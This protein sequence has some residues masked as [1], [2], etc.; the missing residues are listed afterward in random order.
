MTGLYVVLA[1][2]GFSSWL[3]LAHPRKTLL[4]AVFFIPW[5]GLDVD[6]GLRVTAYLVFITPLFAATVFRSLVKTRQ[7]LHLGAFWLIV[8]YAVIWSA[9]QLPFLPVENVVGG[10]LRQ[11][12]VR[13][14]FQILMFLITISPIW[15][16]P[17]YIRDRAGLLQMGKCYLVSVGILALIGWMQLAIWIATGTDPF[18]VG[19]FNGLLGGM[20]GERSGMFQ[21]TG[22]VIYRMSSF[23][24][25]PKGLGIGLAVALLLLQ[26]G[27]SLKGSWGRW[28]WPFLFIS[29]V[30]TF[31]TMALLGWLGATVVQLF[32]SSEGRLKAPDFLSSRHGVKRMFLWS[33]PVLMLAVVAAQSIPVFELIHMRTTTRIVE[34]DR[35]ALEEFNVAVLDFLLAHPWWA[36]VGTGLGNVHLYADSFLPEYAVRYAEG[37]PFV[38]KS[39]ALRWVSELGLL[40]L[41]GF[42]GWIFSTSSKN[43]RLA[44]NFP[45]WQY[46]LG[47]VVK[48]LLPLM[49]LWFVS[50][51]IAPQFYITIGVC[52]ATGTIIRRECLSSNFDSNSGVESCK[53]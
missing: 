43:A 41:I 22:G 6:I 39:G 30:A 18:P 53:Q 40:T 16:V 51:Y 44:R 10:A 25:E 27:V 21:Y 19:F 9:C 35:L 17:T 52:V 23:G 48:L 32:V 20:G 4:V 31:S 8:I 7:R 47:I 45:G 14:T 46:L 28:F 3:A 11:P 33:I 37:T 36:A 1:A 26:A 15:L 49:S 34:S 13:G 42:V 50:G 12:A 2:L 29:M 38:A 24:G 5:S